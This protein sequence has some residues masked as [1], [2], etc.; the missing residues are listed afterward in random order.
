MTLTDLKW[1]VAGNPEI[2]KKREEHL[3]KELEKAREEL[4]QKNIQYASLKVDVE[5]E[6]LKY[7]KKCQVL[8]VNSLFVK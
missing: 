6:E 2:I 4:G 1:S 7:K 8:E 5:K 3:R